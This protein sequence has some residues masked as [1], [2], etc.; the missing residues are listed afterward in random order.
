MPEIPRQVPFCTG[1]QASQKWMLRWPAPVVFADTRRHSGVPTRP[2]AGSPAR[3]VSLAEGSRA[4]TRRSA[5]PLVVALFSLA[6]A[7]GEPA[8][9]AGPTSAAPQKTG[10]F[11]TAVAKVKARFTRTKPAS[12]SSSHRLGMREALQR[13]R[14]ELQLY[15]GRKVERWS[16]RLAYG[17]SDFDPGRS[18]SDNLA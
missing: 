14:E 18:V 5:V 2:V 16:D 6:L 10:R 17:R 9:A 4:M 12:S 8:F 11:K 3:G 1:G 13:A 15:R 7:A